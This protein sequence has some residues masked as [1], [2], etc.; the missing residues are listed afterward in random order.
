MQE[1]NYRMNLLIIMAVK[2][3]LYFYP[4]V[5]LISLKKKVVLYLLIVWGCFSMGSSQTVNR[6]TNA[7]GAEVYKLAQSQPY[8]TIDISK[9]DYPIKENFLK[10]GSNKAPNGS[11]LSY[12]SRYL[13]K[14]GKPWFPIMGE[15]HFIRTNYQDWEASILKMKAAGIEIISTYVIWNFHEEKEGV[16]N[17]TANNDLKAFLQLCKK[18]NIY[19]WLRIGPWSHAEIRYGGF[20]DWLVNKKLALR[21]NDATYLKHTERFFIEQSKQANGWLFKDGGPIIGVQIENELDFKK[22]TDFQHMIALKKLAIDAGFDVPFYSAFAQGPDGQDEFLYTIGGY[23]DSPWSGSTK[24]LFK[25]M[26]FIKPLE[27][28]SDI[29]ADLF[30][31]RDSIITNTYPKIGAEVAGGLQPTYHRRTATSPMDIAAAMF[32]RIAGGLNGLGYYMFHG[33]I[34]PVGETNTLEETRITGYPNDMARIDYD[35]Q[36]PISS[37]GI[38]SNAYNELKLLHLFIKDFGSEFALC[39]ALFPQKMIRTHNSIDTVQLG[40]RIHDDAGFIFLNNYQRH[41]NLPSANNMQLHLQKKNVT[42]ENIPSKPF[43]FPANSNLIMPY[44]LKMEGAVLK[45]ATAQLLCK[46]NNEP[47]KTYLFF[48]NENS[49]FLLSEV[50]LIQSLNKGTVKKEADD[51]YRVSL[52]KNETI[53]FAVVTK[54]QTTFDVIVLAKADALNANKI[55]VDGKEGLLVADATV[56]QDGHQLNIEKLGLQS[57]VHLSVYPDLDFI[58][59][60]NQAINCTKMPSL[61]ALFHYLIEAKKPVAK[62]QIVVKELPTT[63]SSEILSQHLDSINTV[64]SKA[65]K[66]A[67]NQPGSLHQYHLL[68]L[69]EQ[70]KYQV[71]FNLE[72]NKL[73]KDWVASIHY[74]GDILALYNTNNELVYDQY[75]YNGNC[76]IRLNYVLKNSPNFIAQVLPM[77][78][79]YDIYVEDAFLKARKEDW[80]KAAIKN[81]DLLPLYQYQIGIKGK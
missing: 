59:N 6:I 60:N 73:V 49:E 23:P 67:A 28:D 42:I 1:G 18:H 70:A 30:G 78:A 51:L 10:M 13:V 40:I 21:T 81:I 11:T 25:S 64:Y 14:N 68:D 53:H 46:L 79:G 33:G 77:K 17:W 8:Y 43:T 31:K 22:E 3:E 76:N 19:V 16:F 12:N 50:A 58:A 55:M 24:K 47:K 41:L 52:P 74:Q 39:K 20:P 71:G 9:Q 5:N 62:G 69:P 7:I 29:G 4:F 35:F 15:M 61:N 32:T 27:K 34:N 54:K 72:K 57:G 66:Y 75:N 36:A 80:I 45:Y 56:L 38:P 37:M 63:V 26:Y 65:K 44:N 48:A 2:R